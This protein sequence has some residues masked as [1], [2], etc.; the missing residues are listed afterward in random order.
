MSTQTTVDAAMQRLTELAHRSPVHFVAAELGGRA[1][2]GI[3]DEH[4]RVYEWPR[5]APHLCK[6]GREF[7]RSQSLGQHLGATRRQADQAMAGEMDR[8]RMVL[9]LP[10]SWVRFTSPEGPVLLDVS[11]AG[12]DPKFAGRPESLRDLLALG[13]T[14]ENAGGRS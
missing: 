12:V 8:V 6:C 11:E 5:S 2:D 4:G 10:G 7:N 3:I 1:Y 9:R 13:W 14:V